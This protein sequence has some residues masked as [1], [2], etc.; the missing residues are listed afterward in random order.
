MK[1]DKA[2]LPLTR[3]L[4]LGLA[5][6]LSC[7]AQAHAQPTRPTELALND[8]LRE[9]IDLPV[10]P[11]DLAPRVEHLREIAVNT[12]ECYTEHEERA[13][14]VADRR[15]PRWFRE[16]EH[17]GVASAYA[18]GGLLAE[19]H[20]DDAHGEIAI[21]DSGGD[22]DTGPRLVRLLAS[23]NEP[24]AVTFL[25][26]FMARMERAERPH[27][28]LVRAVAEV[29]PR[30]TGND[31]SP[32]APWEPV[33]WARGGEVWPVVTRDWIGWWRAARAD[34]R[35]KWLADGTRRARAALASGDPLARFVAIQRLASSPEDRDAARAS[36]AELLGRADLP[37]NARAY[38]LRYGRR[39]RLPAP[40]RGAGPAGLARAVAS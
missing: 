4:T 20:D 38:L 35:E 17:G 2:N 11:S 28:E 9:R 26:A 5:A 19:P 29:L 1:H 16:L 7:A 33:P 15:C 3:A 34:P 36:W 37:A 13:E 24:V 23:T 6:G 30:I 10:P 40:A 31:I 12:L 21:E 8:S 14:H 22:W 25:V 27:H 32:V 39:H 18:I